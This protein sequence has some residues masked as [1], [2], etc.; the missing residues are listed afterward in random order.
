[1]TH[2]THPGNSTQTVGSNSPQRSE[3]NAWIR[4][5]ENATHEVFEIMLEAHIEFS[6][7][8]EELDG[9]VTAVVGIG[10]QATGVLMMKVSGAAA[11]RI[12]TNLFARDR[13]RPLLDA[14]ESVA[15]ICN[16]IAANFK[17]KLGS[18]GDRCELS[19]PVVVTGSGAQCRAVAGSESLRVSMAYQEHPISITLD[20]E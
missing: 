14:P 12:A 6:R 4:L 7:P 9:T 2:P 11:E 15:E 19:A 1:M 10:G 16:K 8:Q 3:A 20:I 5:L 17:S 13:S 18:L